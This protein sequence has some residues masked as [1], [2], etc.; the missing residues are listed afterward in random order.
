MA[1]LPYKKKMTLDDLPPEEG[2]EESPFF[3]APGAKEA[4][5]KLF[6]RMRDAGMP[7]IMVE[8]ADIGIPESLEGMAT[9]AVQFGRKIGKGIGMMRASGGSKEIDDILA[10]VKGKAEM[11]EVKSAERVLDYSKFEKDPTK[12]MPRTKVSG[13]Q[14]LQTIEN[15]A[16]TQD[17]MASL[18][19][20]KDRNP[21]RYQEVIAKWREKGILPEQD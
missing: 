13:S 20:L 11:P 15:E 18:E 17:R 2:L 19:K 14:G 8:A 21:K 9:K 7:E 16:L 4:K 3:E 1:T 6:D 10:S 5:K 12:S